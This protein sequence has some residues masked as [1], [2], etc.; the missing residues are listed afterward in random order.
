M[1]FPVV[2]DLFGLRD[3]VRG[4]NGNWVGKVMLTLRVEVMWTTRKLIPR[5]TSVR[6]GY[7]WYESGESLLKRGRRPNSVEQTK[8]CPY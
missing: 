2:R 3:L 7:F 4:V 5:F 1:L 6:N 8:S